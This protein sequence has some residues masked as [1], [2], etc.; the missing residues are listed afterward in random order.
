MLEVK[1]EQDKVMV[2][3]YINKGHVCQTEQLEVD[4]GATS[5]NLASSLNEFDCAGR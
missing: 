2:A 4:H 1:V 3:L 5:D